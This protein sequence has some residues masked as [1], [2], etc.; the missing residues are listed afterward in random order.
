[1]V[2]DLLFSC[3]AVFYIQMQHRH[4]QMCSSMWNIIE[5]TIP[6]IM[7]FVIGR[8]LIFVAQA[9]VSQYVSSVQDDDNKRDEQLS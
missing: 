3:Y 6:D 7:P 1:M 9:V 8:V 2:M 5:N 4:N